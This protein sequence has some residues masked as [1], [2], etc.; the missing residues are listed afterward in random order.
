M[1]E[2]PLVGEV[3]LGKRAWI[4]SGSVL[5]YLIGGCS[6]LF[7]DVMRNLPESV[8]DRKLCVV[9][10]MKAPLPPRC[11]K[12]LTFRLSVHQSFPRTTDDLNELL[13]I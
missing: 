10:V 12:E 9:C 3:D 11:N 5:R 2:R 13:N 1:P 6:I 8:S 4:W 7:A